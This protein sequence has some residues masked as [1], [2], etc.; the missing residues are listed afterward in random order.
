MKKSNLTIY[1]T[2]A[3]LLISAVSFLGCEKDITVDFPPA[4]DLIVVEGHI[5]PGQ[6]AYVHLSK[7]SSYFA[8]TDTATLLSYVIGNATVIVSDGVDYDTLKFTIDFH[9]FPYFPFVYKGSKIIGQA[10]HFYTLK[11]MANGQTVTSYTSIP[12]PVKPDSAWF[13]VQGNLDSLGFVWIHFKDPDTTGNCYRFMTKRISH[14]PD[15]SVKDIDFLTNINSVFDDKIF[16][17]TSPD[18]SFNRGHVPHDTAM[19]SHNVEAGFFKK[20]DT[21]IFKYMNIDRPHFD[22]WST[23]GIAA[24]SSGNPFAA[25]IMVKSNI[26]GGLGIWGGYG[27]AYDT[28]IAK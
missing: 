10:N 14:R 4:P 23:E 26:V 13:R 3:L 16:N 19:D 2:V 11:V 25:P 22:F 18:F 5:E 27:A 12:T 28:V 9:N 20:G 6:Y 7:N 24:E 17:G 1:F 15:G 8:P 21:I